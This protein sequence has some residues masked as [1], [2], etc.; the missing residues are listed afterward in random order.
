MLP[1]GPKFF[2][3]TTMRW[4]EEHRIPIDL[5]AGTSMGGLIG[6]SY[7]SGMSAE[8]LRAL[9]T[10]TDWDELF[11]FTPFRYK[12]IR[13]KQDARAYPSRLEF[14]LKHGF[15][16]PPSLNNGQ[17]VDLM[18]AKIAAPYGT[19]ASFDDLPTPF[20]CVAVDLKT[21][22]PVVLDHGSLLGVERSHLERYVVTEEM[23]AA[24]APTRAHSTADRQSGPVILRY[25][26]EEIK[27]KIL[28]QI[29]RVVA[30]LPN[31]NYA[32]RP[33][34]F[35]TAEIP[36]SQG[37]AGI[38]IPK[39]ALQTIKG[40]RVVFVRNERGFEAR[41]VATGLEDDR[42]VEIV[43]GLFAGEAIAV[44]NTFVLKA[45]LGKAEAEHQH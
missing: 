36:L 16:L 25:G 21:A 40:E 22:T 15:A 10:G 30:S 29:A 33:G 11:G 31:P 12:N 34:S 17:Q 5:I 38:V 8:E 37:R 14:G 24:R 7:A 41:Q 45:E 20:R 27:Q 1:P 43:S 28:P 26:Q 35:V 2:D 32:F 3:P 18:L 4:F 23:L 9:L 39:A 42:S 44:S 6:G 19:L 13:R